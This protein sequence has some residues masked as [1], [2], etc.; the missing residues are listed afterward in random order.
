MCGIFAIVSSKEKSID[1]L[2]ALKGLHRRGP[3]S[4]IVFNDD[5]LVIGQT[6]LSFARFGSHTCEEHYSLNKRYF[7]TLNG[8]IYNW[9]Y[10]SQIYLG[11]VV[12][13]DIELLT[14]LMHRFGNLDVSLLEGMYVICVYDKHEKKLNVYNDFAGE[15]TVY[16]YSSMD[17][18]FLSSELTPILEYIKPDLNMGVLR[19]YLKTRHY[20]PFS[21]TCWNNIRKLT[22]GECI[23]LDLS[24]LKIV[25]RF[26]NGYLDLLDENYHRELNLMTDED[27][28]QHTNSLFATAAGLICQNST[29]TTVSSIFSGGVDSSICSSY[30]SAQLS[31]TLYS[32]VALSFDGKDEHARVM[33][34]ML[35]RNVSTLDVIEET[36]VENLTQSYEI[37]RQPLPTHSFVSQLIISKYAKSF[38]A[39][40]LFNGDIA[41][42]LFFGYPLY[43]SGKLTD[44][45][46]LSPYSDLVCDDNCQQISMVYENAVEALEKIECE[47][48]TE[49]LYPLIDPYVNGSGIGLLCGDLATSS[50]G[51]ESRCFYTNK[52]ICKLAVNLPTRFKSGNTQTARKDLL[53]KI[54]LQRFGA[55]PLRKQG[56]S[57]YPEAQYSVNNY[58][59]LTK[60]ILSEIYQTEFSNIPKTQPKDFWKMRNLS[61]FLEFEFSEKIV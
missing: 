34:D 50:L 2:G 24:D 25:S 60:T 40:I 13:S 48:T 4:Q 6:I 49:M 29:N 46:S 5:N 61:E 41:D 1:H 21:E 3:D 42:E 30:V 51:M 9:K 59:S 16:Y 27:V 10:L 53:N 39:K 8:E 18:F 32:E 31:Q 26:N 35:D 56:F 17:T 58:S 14:S 15:K 28:I 33:S 47:Q 43:Q 38:G 19:K 45:V 55:Q 22:P 54:F 57:G 52:N 23:C 11:K 44:V 7:V 20:N 12:R 37:T 36:Y